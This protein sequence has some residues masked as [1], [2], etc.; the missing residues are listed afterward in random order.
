MLKRITAL[1]VCC[2]AFFVACERSPESKLVGTWRTA[3]AENAGKVRFET[4]HTFSGGE[5]S[6]TETHQPPVIPDN[7]EWHVTGR[8]LVLN[9]QG[10]FHDRK[11]SELV[12][13]MRDDDHIVLRQPSGMETTL[14]RLK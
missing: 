6:L 13:T 14:E 12:L 10:E 2:A 11:Q 8:K 7:G 3:N 9:F 4:N 5:W 1:S